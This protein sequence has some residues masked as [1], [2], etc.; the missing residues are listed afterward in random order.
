MHR[1][2]HKNRLERYLMQ[3]HKNINEF[4]MSK[5]NV[6]EMALELAT[7]KWPA[8]LRVNI[9]KLN[10][11]INI[12]HEN[13]ITS[14]EILQ[15]GRIFYFNIKTI[16]KRIESLKKQGIIPK[17]TILIVSEESFERYVTVVA[18]IERL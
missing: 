8:I 16:E 18:I 3:H 11:V 15:H 10:N 7:A 1:A 12:L 17:I 9:A 5:L 4:L 2:I 14:D 6:D 13:K